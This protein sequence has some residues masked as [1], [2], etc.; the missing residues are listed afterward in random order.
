MAIHVMEGAEAEGATT[1]RK[2]TATGYGCANKI[3]SL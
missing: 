3:K 2:T 1:L